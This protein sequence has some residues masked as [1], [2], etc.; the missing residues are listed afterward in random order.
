MISKQQV[1]ADQFS[2]EL[3]VDQRRNESLSSILSKP[4]FTIYIFL[5]RL[6]Y[7]RRFSLHLFCSSTCFPSS[8]YWYYVVIR[9]TDIYVEHLTGRKTD[10]LLLGDSTNFLLSLSILSSCTILR[11]WLAPIFLVELKH[12]LWVEFGAKTCWLE[13]WI[14]LVLIL[15]LL[16]VLNL[17]QCTFKTGLA[18]GL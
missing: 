13:L 12:I 8:F 9:S 16:R 15:R 4:Y 10:C 14:F 17:P 5:R 18:T 1:L 2:I 6:L 11:R 3:F 7:N